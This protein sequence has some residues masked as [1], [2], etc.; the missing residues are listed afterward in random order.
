[1]KR[2]IFHGISVSAGIAIGR[3]FFLA[4]KF[5]QVQAAREISPTQTGTELA[6]LDAAFESTRREIE[7]AGRRIP[8]SLKDQTGILAA[9]LMI[10]R[11]PK[12]I[13]AARQAVKSDFLSAEWALEKAVAAIAESFSL[14]EDSYIRERLQD[15]RAVAERIMG[16]LRG[17]LASALPPDEPFILL[18]H[19]I[20]PADT[21]E[22]S[23]KQIIAFAT[24]EGSR[25][26]HTG[27]MA[28]SLQIPAVVG[29]GA[30]EEA[31]NDGDMLVLDA[32]E[33]LILVNPDQA[34]LSR[35]Q[36]QQNKFSA[37]QATLRRNAKLPAEP[38]GGFRV[39]VRGNIE[40]PDEVMA[41]L[42]AGGEGIGLY[43]TEYGF[44]CRVEP[45]SEEDLFEEYRR[46]LS[47][48]AP[49]KVVF[50]TLDV[51]ADKMLW[52]QKMLEEA[53]PA[54]GLRGIRYCLRN[55]DVF[56]RQLRAI[57]R[58]SMHGNAALMFPMISGPRELHQAKAVL[59]EVKQEL[60]TSKVPFDRHMP[61]GLMIELPAAAMTADILAREVDFFSIGTN[62]LI[63]YSI[64]VDR[65]NKHVSS[66]HQP[67]HP[68]IVRTIKLVVD[69]AHM[70]GVP[71]SICGEMASDPYCLLIL[72]GMGIDEISMAPQAIPG[73]KH[74]IR[75]LDL[76]ECTRL[77]REAH[78]AGSIQAVNRLVKLT[79]AQAFP[80]ELPFY[81]SLLDTGDFA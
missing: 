61:V 23:L 78:D 63:Q 45:P 25:T 29:V 69:M 13:Q 59:N 38:P 77:A 67:L 71:V 5:P 64:A 14:I 8:P 19:D 53:N 43:R 26:A 12:L 54:L 81:I 2:N 3:A 20:T 79:L 11:D 48:A 74:I 40:T 36:T 28:R 65:T 62:D 24:E 68:G 35:Y 22:L 50:R 49:H 70:A 52:D 55:Q 47:A 7:D 17:R 66:L 73:I 44:I 60:D 51:G 30:L 18:A 6:R 39:A 46:L 16:H 41:V 1:M 80:D 76:D 33:G 10:C 42:K 58:A 72:L 57:L 32:L 27:I 75:H 37:F 15:V 4:R 34:V 9:H 31:V 21:L 56:R